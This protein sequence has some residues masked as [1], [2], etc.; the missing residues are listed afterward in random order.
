MPTKKEQRPTGGLELARAYDP[1]APGTYRVLVDRLWPRGVSKADA[2]LDEWPKEL[3]PSPDLRRWFGHEPA[4]FAEFTRRYRRELA[5]PEATGA[6]VRLRDLA[7]SKRVVLVTA[8]RD[9]EHSGARVLE[10]VLTGRGD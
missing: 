4:R 3:T 5:E 1:P 9:L 2:A 6:L 8:T 7:Q 10:Q